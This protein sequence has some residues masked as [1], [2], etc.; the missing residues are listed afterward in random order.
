MIK[1]NHYEG[2]E[3]QGEMSQDEGMNNSRG[4]GKHQEQEEIENENKAGL[5]SWTGSKDQSLKAVLDF[6]KESR[7]AS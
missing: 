5:Q 2:S 3:S 7:K 6:L 1:I 4:G